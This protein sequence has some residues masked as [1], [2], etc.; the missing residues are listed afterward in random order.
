MLNK[1]MLIGN[2]GKDPEVRHLESGSVVASF[3]VATNENYRDKAGEWQTVTEWHNIVA[4][5]HL[6]ERVERD[7]RKGSRVYIEGKLTTRKWQDRDGN[8][9]YTTE[10]VANLLRSLDRKERDENSIGGGNFPSAADEPTIQK[11]TLNSPTPQTNS[12]QETPQ[13]DDLPF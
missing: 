3:S 11:S 4:W 10:V 9:R 13:D 8:D 1:V 7:L 6:A 5:R 2:L 12:T